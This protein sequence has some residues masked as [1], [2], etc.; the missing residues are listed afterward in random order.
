MSKMENRK[1]RATSKLLPILM[2]VE[3]QHRVYILNAR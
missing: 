1:K 3:E 2:F